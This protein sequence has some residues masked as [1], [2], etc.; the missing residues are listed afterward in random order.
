MI[1]PTAIIHEHSEIH[2]SVEIGPWCVIGA[3][4]KIGKDTKLVSH[5]VVEGST[6]IGEG[7]VIFPFT[8]LGAVPQ[9]LKYQ[10]EQTRL[11]IG[12]HNTIRESVTMNLGTLQGGGETRIGDHNLI[13]A[14]THLG[15]DCILGNHVILAN[16]AGLAGHVEID[17]YANLGGM[18]GVSQFVRIG[19]HSYVTGQSGLEKDVPPFSIACGARPCK[20]RGANIVGL[21]RR[22][23]QVDTI[24]KIN[25][26][27]K[28]WVRPEIQKEPC[29]YEIKL[30]YGEI[31]EIQ[32]FI[33]FIEET[34]NGAVR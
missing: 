31:P 9:D 2:A 30:Q 8:V 19:A 21:R 25:E 33:K 1:H 34:K 32:Q 15:H 11:I 10:G 13:M 24:Q 23:F 12:N 6:T 27:I 22:G 16:G 29:L 5:V 3:G 7:N 18:V 4:V 14:Y 26:V 28:L 20:L 17:D